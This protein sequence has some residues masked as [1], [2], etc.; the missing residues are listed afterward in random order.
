MAALKESYFYS[1]EVDQESDR[2]KTMEKVEA[3]GSSATIIKFRLPDG[4][5]IIEYFDRSDLVRYLFEFIK[6]SV[7]EA[8]DKPLE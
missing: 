4:S 7:S 3:V 6:V 8:Q 1:S 5:N 2:I